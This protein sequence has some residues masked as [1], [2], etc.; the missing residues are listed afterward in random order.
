MSATTYLPKVL[1]ALDAASDAGLERLFELL[2]IDSISTDPACKPNCR[3]AAEWCARTLT[4][5]GFD[6]SVRPTTGHP[7]RDEEDM[8]RGFPA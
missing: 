3:A 7:A 6:A 1:K 5:I 2:R 4:D 8:S